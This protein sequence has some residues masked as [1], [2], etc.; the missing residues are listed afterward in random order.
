VDGTGT[1]AEKGP[2]AMAT[3]SLSF[4]LWYGVFNRSD[5]MVRIKVR[6]RVGDTALVA[7]P[8]QPLDALGQNKVLAVVS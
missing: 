8:Q 4:F 2:R 7:V 5:M 6:V 3:G 1:P